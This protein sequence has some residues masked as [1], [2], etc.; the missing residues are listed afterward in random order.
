MNE[1]PSDPDTS[2]ARTG[3]EPSADDAPGRLLFRYITVEEWRDYR[4]IM[5]V[6]AGTSFA[7]FTP[8]DVSQR[9]AADGT[10]LDAATVG[11][12]LERLR[13]WGNLSVSSSIGN[14]S[15]LVDYYRRRNRYLITPAA[16]EVH[17]VVQGVLSRVDDVRDVSTGRLGSIRAG[18]E[19]L[20][21]MDISL[22]DPD[23][24]AEMVRTV[25]DPMA[26]FTTEITQFFAAIN[27][28]QSRYDLTPDEFRFFA[29][30]LVGYVAE[31][32]DEIE[33]LSR[34]IGHLLDRLVPQVPTIC[35][36]VGT[37]L[38]GRVEQAGLGR[39]VS[40]SHTP[41]SAIE[42]WE[43]LRAWFVRTGRRSSRIE[44]LGEDAV[45]AIR[46]LTQNL[47]RLSREGVGATSRRADFLRLAQMF[48]ASAS[49]DPTVV[50]GPVAGDGPVAVD[51]PVGVAPDA[52]R[53]AAAA[54]GVYPSSHY[55][56]LAE[57][58]EDPVSP[59]VSWWQAPR[60]A[61]PISLRRRGDRTNR[62]HA[63]PM[64]NRQME[65]KLL[66]QRRS[67][68]LETRRRVDAEL[69]SFDGL[70]GAELR[71]AALARLQQLVSR[72]VFAL[73]VRP[74]STRRGVHGVGHEGV[75][76]EDGV[77]CRVRRT[78]GSDLA[79]RSPDGE[80][81]FRDLAITLEWVIAPA[82]HAPAELTTE[83]VGAVGE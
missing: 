1:Q 71:P 21:A 79:V 77:R 80:L 27:Q 8:D 82:D 30:V 3:A 81:T 58:A 75:H 47:T 19:A 65:R 63:S 18:L 12:R 40:V 50:D 36:S 66:L 6:F 17:D 15:S 34:P 62:G 11:D 69:L 20:A 54:F 33:R 26:S 2:G 61:V 67:E 14:P 32:L 23:V 37:G 42:D 64:R 29:E 38:A 73:G 55:G 52:H 48:A 59:S 4:A 74:A 70:D 49:P 53:I 44:R 7:E 41:G 39:T 25:F 13:T 22:V 45:A 78:N 56:V 51:G 46:T 57:D 68:E 16:Q 9:L 31:R 60:A 43:H 35:S 28:W 5:T 24:L 76:E 83:S 10:V 72:A